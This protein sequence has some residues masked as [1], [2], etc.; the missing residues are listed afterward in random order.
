MR[1]CQKG[2][3]NEVSP[4]GKN[5]EFFLHD[6]HTLGKRSAKYQLYKKFFPQKIYCTRLTIYV[7]KSENYYFISLKEFHRKDTKS[8]CFVNIKI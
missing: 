1:H 6:L 8:M 3:G 4:Y 2:L 5:G 7:K